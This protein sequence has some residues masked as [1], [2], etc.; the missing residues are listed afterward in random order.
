M[1]NEKR[2]VFDRMPE[3]CDFVFRL[4]RDD[5]EPAEDTGN[6]LTRRIGLM[7]L[8]LILLVVRKFR[9]HRNRMALLELTDDQL[10][11]VGLSRSQAYGDYSRYCRGHSHRLE[12][13][14][15]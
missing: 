4:H 3:R 2:A 1:K 10:K 8:R 9:E 13:K 12:R 15:P 7:L 11:D 6:V 5:D 14:G